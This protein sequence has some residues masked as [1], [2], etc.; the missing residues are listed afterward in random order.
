MLPVAESTT[1][2]QIIKEDPAIQTYKENLLKQVN[3]Y[4]QDQL[5]RFNEPGKGVY[6]PLSIK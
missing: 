6:L 3:D 2:T 5:T 1:T 4:I